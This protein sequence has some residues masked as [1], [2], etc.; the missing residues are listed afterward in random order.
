MRRTTLLHA[1]SSRPS[2]VRALGLPLPLFWLAI[3]CAGP[4]PIASPA[5]GSG[6]VTVA[7]SGGTAG[8]A[9]SGGT[10][11]AGTGGIAPTDGGAGGPP[12]GGGTGGS[13]AGSGGA[14]AGGTG[15]TT[16]P[17]REPPMG[18]G[19]YAGMRPEPGTPA[20]V[21]NTRIF[22]DLAGLV[23]NQTAQELLIVVGQNNKIMRYRAG[24]P[25]ADNFDVV[26]PG[27]EHLDGMKGI[28]LGPDGAL[29][30]CEARHSLPPRV[31]RSDGA[32]DR[33]VTVVD[34]FQDSDGGSQSFTSPWYVSVRWDGNAYFT[35]T[36][37]RYSGIP[38]KRLFRIDPAGKLTLLKRYAKDSDLS[39]GGA[40][41]IALSPNQRAFYVSTWNH[42]GH[43]QLVR[44]DLAP[45]G[46]VAK[47]TLVMTDTNGPIQS[48]DGLCIDQAENIYLCTGGGGVRTY[49]PAGALLGTIAVPGATDCTFGG[50]DMKTLFVATSGGVAGDKNLYQVPMNIPGLQ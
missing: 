7:G 50:A 42:P 39:E 37:H 22:D 2:I 18:P 27:A 3:G 44:F 9:G 28:D 29:W 6:G 4:D 11:S 8:S 1:S 10:S 14:P 12:D 24:V 5:A 48:V 15:G 23:W 45:D 43:P 17:G 33:P 47:E 31:S 16:T 13:V 40:F 20:S 36:P 46:A 32:Y 41:G 34:Q 19:P 26:R 38:N 25:D 21:G 49:G 30:V 35:D